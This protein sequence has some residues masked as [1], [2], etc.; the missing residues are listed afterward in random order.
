MQGLPWSSAYGRA[1]RGEPDVQIDDIL[2]DLYDLTATG[3]QQRDGKPL[4]PYPRRGS[5]AVQ[6]TTQSKYQ[7]LARAERER[8]RQQ[9]G[10]AP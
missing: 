4:P 2:A 1:L 9:R 3:Y 6:E 10:A 7:H 5:E 8:M